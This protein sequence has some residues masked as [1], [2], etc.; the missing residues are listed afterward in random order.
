[1]TY[2]WW[3]LVAAFLF[4]A[5]L[6]WGLTLPV[7]GENALTGETAAL[8]ELAEVIVSLPPAVMF[9]VIFLKNISVVVISVLLGPVLLLF[10]VFALIINGG[11]IG[12]ASIFVVAEKSAAFLLAGILPHGIIELPALIMGEAVA[13]SFGSAMI[14]GIFSREKKKLILPNIRSNVKYL[15]ISLSLLLVAAII[16]TFITPSVLALFDTPSA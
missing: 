4:I 11:I 13:L 1:M 15:L 8:G 6:L 10:P 2:R 14:L 16:E 3:L 7:E 12:Q 9:L 5:G